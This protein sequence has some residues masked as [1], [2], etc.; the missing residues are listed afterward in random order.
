MQRYKQETGKEIKLNHATV[1]NH[2]KGKNTRAQNNAQKAWL[3]PEEV[4]VI[5][6]YIIELGNHEFP[7]SHQWLN[8]HVDKIL[9]AWLRD[10]FPIGGVRKK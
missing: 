4:E 2:T 3:T 10:H 1:I 7:L 9:G 5:I 6:A 8:E